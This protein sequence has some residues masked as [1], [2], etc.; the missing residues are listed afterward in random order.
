MLNLFLFCFFFEKAG[1]KIIL[2]NMVIPVKLGPLWIA[3]A[4]T[5]YYVTQRT[6]LA[7]MAMYGHAG[8]R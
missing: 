6:G 1:R 7:D 8:P 2:T 4:I 5:L 3:R